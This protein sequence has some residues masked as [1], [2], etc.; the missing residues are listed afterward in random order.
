MLSEFLVLQF[1]IQQRQATEGWE[2]MEERDSGNMYK[3]YIPVPHFHFAKGLMEKLCLEEGFEGEVAWC[4]CLG[5]QCQAKE[6]AKGEGWSLKEQ[7]SFK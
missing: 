5:R 1:K 7:E 3:Q 2:E 4:M 6:A